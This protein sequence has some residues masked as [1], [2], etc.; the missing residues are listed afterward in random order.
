MGCGELH[1]NGAGHRANLNIWEC[2]KWNPQIEYIAI[3]L[4]SIGCFHLYPLNW[5]EN[6]ADGSRVTGLVPRSRSPTVQIVVVTVSSGVIRFTRGS[7]WLGQKTRLP[8]QRLGSY[9]GCTPVGLSGTV[10][11]VRKMRDRLFA[12][13]S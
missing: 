6:Q 9:Q 7:R 1:S 8:S 13:Q 5:W 12:S 10:T 2:F 3:G 4:T 11:V